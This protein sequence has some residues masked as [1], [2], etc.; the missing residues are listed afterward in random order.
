MNILDWRNPL[1]RKRFWALSTLVVVAFLATHPEMRLLVPFLDAIGLDVFLILVEVQFVAL[2]SGAVR[3]VFRRAWPLMAPI[4]RAADRLSTSTSSLRFTRE[5]FRYGVCHW[6]GES[7]PRIW[8]GLHKLIRAA[9]I[10]PGQ[11]LNRTCGP[12][13]TCF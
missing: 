3:P 9:R 2:L 6:V 11:S 13:P 5:F 1:W 7:G 12:R 8:L 10:G 4:I